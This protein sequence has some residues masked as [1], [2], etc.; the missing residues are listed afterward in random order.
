M[1]IPAELDVLRLGLS[2]ALRRVI[3]S[4]PFAVLVAALLI[5][6]SLRA[7]VLFAAVVHLPRALPVG[8]TLHTA[9]ETPEGEAFTARLAGLVASKISSRRL[10]R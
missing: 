5:G 1:L 6:G 4:L 2:V 7:T 8:L 3:V 10:R 9:G